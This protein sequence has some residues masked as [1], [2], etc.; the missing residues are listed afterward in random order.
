ML[1]LRAAYSVRC[2]AIRSATSLKG[3]G[4][5]DASLSPTAKL[6]AMLKESLAANTIGGK[7]D[8][9]S[10][11]AGSCVARIGMIP[12]VSDTTG[13]QS[14]NFIRLAYAVINPGR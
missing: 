5:D 7:V 13:Y 8:V 6:A 9:E 3:G 14:S 1:R 11:S 2:M 12:F 10:R 4:G